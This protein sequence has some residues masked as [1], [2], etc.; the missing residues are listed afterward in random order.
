[1]PMFRRLVPLVLAA[2]LAACNT[3]ANYFEDEKDGTE[4]DNTAF[5]S[6]LTMSG[7]V[8]EQKKPIEY[9]PRAPIAMPG[10]A[11]LP[12]PQDRSAAEDAV[13]FPVD[14]DQQDAARMATLR[15]DGRALDRRTELG[16]ARALPGEIQATAAGR[17][18]ATADVRDM[19]GNVSERDRLSQKD[20]KIT[21]KN[22]NRTALLN[23]DGTA[24]P[25]ANL[26]VPPND[27]RTPSAGAA[28]PNADDIDNSEWI[29]KQLYLKDD[30]RPARLQTDQGNQN[31]QQVLR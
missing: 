11:D 8:A 30:R 27:Y 14:Q 25:R 31:L 13:N 22:P 19:H 17:A 4:V 7:M 23:E 2:G 1:M 28:V 12:V 26:A 29:R 20:L 9:G 21:F 6:L 24:A 16:D 10:S 3:S 5:G 18:R 15:A